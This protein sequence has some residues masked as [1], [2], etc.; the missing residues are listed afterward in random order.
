MVLWYN[1]TMARDWGNGLGRGE[2]VLGGGKWS[3]EG[4]NGLQ[5]GEIVS[6]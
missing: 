5:R 2:M 6:G 3:Q 4:G 1:G